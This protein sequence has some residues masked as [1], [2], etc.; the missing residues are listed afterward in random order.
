MKQFDAEEFV[1][2]LALTVWGLA[3][4]AFIIGVV[5]L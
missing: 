4:G 5:F 3:L 1:T 2:Y